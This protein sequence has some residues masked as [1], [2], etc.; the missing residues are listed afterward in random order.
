MPQV[1]FEIEGAKPLQYAA[2]PHIAFSL[3]INNSSEESIHTVVLRCQVQLEV[4]RRS[5]TLQEQQSLADLF[6]APGQWGETLRSKL[7]ANTTVIVPQFD[8]STV[9]DVPIP[10]TFDFNV[11]VT[12]YFGGLQ[13][14]EAPI[15]FYFGGTIFYTTAGI[16]QVSPIS[17]EQE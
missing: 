16:V 14:G 2:A 11:A 10:C 12:K 8:G 1:T 4:A 13:N 7:W 17:L 15:G 5:Y 3:R 9:V 6:G